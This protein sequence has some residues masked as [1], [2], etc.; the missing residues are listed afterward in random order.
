MAISLLDT[1]RVLASFDPPRGSLRGAPWEEY[2]EWAIAHGL[3]PLASY[4]LQYRLPGVD[5]PE[6]VRDRLLSVYSGS[7]NDN[8]MKLVNF[9][10][11]V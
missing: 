4:N 9:K 6:W 3:A 2:V 1:I 10:R 11:C 8:V 7:V 5:A